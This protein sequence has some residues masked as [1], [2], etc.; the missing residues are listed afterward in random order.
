MQ[1][2]LRELGDCGAN[3]W[4]QRVR[5]ARALSKLGTVVLF[6][7]I[8]YSSYQQLTGGGGNWIVG[9]YSIV[10]VDEKVYLRENPAEEYVEISKQRHQQIVA[11]TAKRQR[12]AT[13]LYSSVVGGLLGVSLIVASL[14][15]DP[16]F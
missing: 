16:R 12:S 8:M 15:I 13:V 5:L 2:Q 3:N 9:D 14:K 4:K 11:E 10:S 1:N 6:L 7:V